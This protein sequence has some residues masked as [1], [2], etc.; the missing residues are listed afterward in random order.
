MLY[1]STPFCGFRFL[2]QRIASSYQLGL[3]V[4]RWAV[5]SDKCFTFIR[6]N[7]MIYA[8]QVPFS[9]KVP[10]FHIA[11]AFTMLFKYIWE[12]TLFRIRQLWQ[13]F[14]LVTSDSESSWGTHVLLCGVKWHTESSSWG[15]K[16]VQDYS[17]TW[18]HLF[19]LSGRWMLASFLIIFLF[20]LWYLCAFLNGICL[21]SKTSFVSLLFYCFICFLFYMFFACFI[22]WFKCGSVSWLCSAMGGK[23]WW[24][25]RYLEG[26]Y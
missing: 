3:H 8:V 18:W 20:C 13:D 14:L 19:T 26:T 22:G 21:W 12:N 6:T 4:Q 1:K 15:F 7:V 24:S 9:F 25:G 2:Q 17:H 10:F 16:G 5:F 23:S 11:F